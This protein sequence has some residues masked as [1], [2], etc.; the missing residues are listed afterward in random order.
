MSGWIGVGGKISGTVGEAKSRDSVQASLRKEAEDRVDSVILRPSDVSG[1]YD[2]SRALKTTL[3]GS[4]RPITSDDLVAFGKNINT[5]KDRFTKGIT[6]KQVIELSITDP[7]RYTGKEWK[8]Q[9]DIDKARKEIRHAVPHSVHHG[10]I[11]F[12]T[13]SGTDKAGRHHVA[14]RFLSWGA[15]IA[16]PSRDKAGNPDWRKTALWLKNQP[17]KFDCDCGR[18]QFWFRYIATIGQYNEGRAEMGFP[19]IRNP[20]L[21]GVACKHVLRVMSDLQQ[22]HASVIQLLA[23]ALE[24][25]HNATDGTGK[26]KRVAPTKMSQKDAEKMASGKG[27]ETIGKGISADKVKMNKPSSQTK[28]A[29]KTQKTKIIE[30]SGDKIDL[31]KI[32]ADLGISIE[33]LMKKYGKA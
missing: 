15:A 25:A 31:N 13:P 10:L 18:H 26:T 5:V 19:K 30:S 3:G 4:M 7:K 32:A 12:I 27:R 8:D 11:R 23:K 6:A 21:N 9:S 29:R 17:L 22:G 1:Q 14:V 24:K 33:Q 2:V 20:R 16:S 28:T